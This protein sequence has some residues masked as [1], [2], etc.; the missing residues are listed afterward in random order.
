MAL[1][2][3]QDLFMSKSGFPTLQHLLPA[4]WLH[5]LEVKQ[6]TDLSKSELL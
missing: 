2:K 3:E 1:G 5:L 4:F 6:N